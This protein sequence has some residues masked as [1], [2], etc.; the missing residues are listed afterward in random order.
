MPV[1]GGL[2]ASL[3]RAIALD[4]RNPVSSSTPGR[5]DARE[6]SLPIPQPRRGPRRDSRFREEAIR[7]WRVG[8]TVIR[9]FALA[10]TLCVLSD[11]QAA[12]A[13]QTYPGPAS[14]AQL[15]RRADVVVVGDVAS[16]VG[17]W[18]AARTEIHTRVELAVA[19]TLKGT[20]APGLSFTQ[21][22]GRI[23]DRITTVAGAV[24][25]ETGQR[26]LVFLERRPDGSLRLVDPF[27]GTFR[28]ERDPATG[29]DDAVRATGAPAA[30]RIP[31]DHVRGEVR[32]ALGGAS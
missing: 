5:V 30:S 24:T 14:V 25:F 26:V 4:P 22:G 20:A 29:R 6:W 9:C 11:A 17:A 15:A 7:S 19:E 31:L 28:V 10:A 2:R 32:R 3:D 27:H 13:S 12:S 16:V 18:D 23:G 8:W 1:G 21:I